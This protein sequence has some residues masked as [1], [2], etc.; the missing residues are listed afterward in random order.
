[1]EGDVLYRDVAVFNG[2]L[3]QYF[4]ALC[5]RVFGAVCERSRFATW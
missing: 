4:N 1:M 2:P 3:S 5:F